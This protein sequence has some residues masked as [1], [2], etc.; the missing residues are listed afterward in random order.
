MKMTKPDWHLE[1]SQSLISNHPP[2]LKDKIVLEII[3]ACDK[4]NPPSRIS[5]S[6]ISYNMV[7]ECNKKIIGD[8]ND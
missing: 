4:H 8:E 3:C 7:N 1:L 5:L 6:V 2:I